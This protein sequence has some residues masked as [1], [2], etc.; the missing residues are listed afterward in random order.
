MVALMASGK[1]ASG[2]SAKGIVPDNPSRTAVRARCFRRMTMLH[3]ITEKQY[4]HVGETRGIEDHDHDLIHFLSSRL[5]MLWRCD[6]YIA[7]AD[8]NPELQAFW[9]G[10]KKQEMANVEQ[11]RELIKEHVRK[12][13]F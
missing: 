2:N 9:R 8:G 13:C 1:W 11:A 7:N 3:A 5:D 10:I 4:A 12:N 6:Q